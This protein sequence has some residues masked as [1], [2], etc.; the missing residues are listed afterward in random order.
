[1]L[2]RASSLLFKRVYIQ[3]GFYTSQLLKHNKPRCKNLIVPQ[4]VIYALFQCRS[5]IFTQKGLG[6][7]SSIVN[8]RLGEI[9]TTLPYLNPPVFF[10][11]AD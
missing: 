9:R 6:D 7:A 8:Y 5:K 4:H 10:I 1:M 11:I 2:S 3:P